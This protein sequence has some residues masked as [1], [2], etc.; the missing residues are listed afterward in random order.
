MHFLFFEFFLRAAIGN[1]T[2]KK[3]L[4]ED[5]TRLATQAIEAYA[6]AVVN[7]HYFAFLYIYFRNNPN[8]TLRTEYDEV[9]QLIQ[10]RRATDT[11]STSVHNLFCADLDFIEVS[12][13]GSAA[14]GGDAITQEQDDFKLL[15]PPP[16]EEDGESGDERKSAREHDEA[17][18]KEIKDLI[19]RDRPGGNG[20]GTSRLSYF[21]KMKS[22]L[23][24][25]WRALLS[26]DTPLDK[27]RAQQQ[28]RAS[29]ASLREFTKAS[30]K[31][32]KDSDVIMGWTSQGK[33]YMQTMRCVINGEEESGVCKKWETVY[34][35]MCKAVELNEE[36]GLEGDGDGKQFEMEEALMYSEFAEV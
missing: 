25:D 20:D 30:R 27:K 15:P 12:V 32:K 28:S 10:T 23:E 22:K 8:S 18:A 3:R 13:P 24:E 21:L 36:E 11:T 14:T 4:E 26:A 7:N 19:D 1:A 5:E 2:W 17:V 34:K 31:S 16:D 35:K 29:K 9:P 6:N 33:Q